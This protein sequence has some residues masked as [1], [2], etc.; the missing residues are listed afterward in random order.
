MK[1]AL[2]PALALALG[3]ALALPAA[4]NGLSAADASEIRLLVPNADLSDLTAAQIAGLQAVIYG[5]DGPKAASIRA[6]LN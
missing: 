4:A 6:I 3:S 5:G 2:L 1:F